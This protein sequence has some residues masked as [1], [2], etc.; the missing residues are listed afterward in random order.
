MEN[1]RLSSIETGHR[2]YLKI[3]SAESLILKLLP[4]RL[5]TQ[6]IICIVYLLKQSG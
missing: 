1:K 5:I 6:N 4:Q 3:I 2:L